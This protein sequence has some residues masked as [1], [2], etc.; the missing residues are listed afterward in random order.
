MKK[1]LVT[2]VAGFIGSHLTELLL[3]NNYQVIGIDNFDAFY[4][5]EVKIKNVETLK[6]HPNFKFLEVSILDKD[7]LAKNLGYEKFDIVVHLAAKAGIRPSLIAPGDYVATNIEGYN[8]ILEL[9]RISGWKKIV[10]GS[11]SSVY[12]T[13]TKIPFNEAD[14][15]NNVISPYAFSKKAGEELSQ[16]YFKLYNLSIVNLRFFTV[17]GPR[18]RPD[19]AIH[20]FL[21]ANMKGEAIEIFGDGSMSRD[22]TFVGD[23]VEGIKLSIEK[24]DRSETKILETY[25]L[26]NSSPVTL[27]ELIQN[28]E[29]VTKNKTVINYKDVPL[30]D[31]PLTYADISKAQKDLGY[32]PVTE[33]K[34]GLEHFY[35]WLKVN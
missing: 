33:L 8:N 11:S 9:A 15:I 32:A 3:K 2:G 13:N 21:K 27:N 16:L 34:V 17:Y 20:K 30:G 22:Y 18:Q 4:S 25:N 19:L 35:Q 7:A 26:G 29:A 23:I 24:L 28:I 10:F 6:S 1:V 31:V 5:K 14:E 12:G